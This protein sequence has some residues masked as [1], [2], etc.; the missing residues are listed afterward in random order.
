MNRYADFILEAKLNAAPGFGRPPASANTK[1]PTKEELARWRARSDKFREDYLKKHP[2]SKFKDVPVRG[3]IV[4]RSK[5]ISSK[6]W[7]KEMTEHGVQA[8][9]DLG[10]RGNKIKY[11]TGKIAAT[12]LHAFIKTKNRTHLVE[13][14]TQAFKNYRDKMK[15]EDRKELDKEAEQINDSPHGPSRTI[16]RKAGKGL[17]FGM[18]GL[19]A[20]AAMF[21]GVVPADIAVF[22][23]VKVLDSAFEATKH[24][25]HE[26]LSTLIVANTIHKFFNSRDSDDYAEEILQKMKQKGIEPDEDSKDGDNLHDNEED[27]KTEESEEEKLKRIVT[28]KFGPSVPVDKYYLDDNGDLKLKSRK[29]ADA[30]TT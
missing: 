6:P 26:P 30:A 1:K 2:N 16:L 25:L 24:S 14:A 27:T 21:S 15:P 12:A 19:A 28:E 8:L 23:G 11:A 9:H 3:S 5:K 17:L 13:K 4:T 20:G 18:I 22:L 10:L 29:S 7:A